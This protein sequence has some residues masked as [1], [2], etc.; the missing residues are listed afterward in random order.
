[1]CFRMHQYRYTDNES[2]RT[3]K[4]LIRLEIFV[5]FIGKTMGDYGSFEFF[6]KFG[7]GN[8]QGLRRLNMVWLKT[9]PTKIKKQFW[10]RKNCLKF[11]VLVCM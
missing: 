8:L 10:S 7:F 3:V 5:Q 2:K 11:V 4:E 1:M 6:V 9:K